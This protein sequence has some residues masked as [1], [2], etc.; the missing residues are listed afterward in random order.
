[1]S[2]SVIEAKCIFRKVI[3]KNSNAIVS[4][5][6]FA[7]ILST[8]HITI[9]CCVLL[10]RDKFFMWSTVDYAMSENSHPISVVI[11]AEE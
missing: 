2:A 11:N 7:L 8:E 6:L 1:M 10:D 4:L 9:A 3:S 5:H